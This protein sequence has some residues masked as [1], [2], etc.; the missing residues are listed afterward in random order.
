[1][2]RSS[3][4]GYP[5]T[6]PPRRPVQVPGREDFLLK[7][8]DVQLLL[9]GLKVF[10]AVGSAEGVVGGKKLLLSCICQEAKIFGETK[11][12]ELGRL[13]AGQHHSGIFQLREGVAFTCGVSYDG[14]LCKCRCCNENNKSRP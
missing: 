12:G 5:V 6:H 1:M 8:S 10:P 7:P 14:L 4:R 9:V 2:T 13:I 11:L 3:T